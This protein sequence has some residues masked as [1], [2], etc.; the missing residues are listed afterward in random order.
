MNLLLRDGMMYIS[1]D[2]SNQILPYSVYSEDH[3]VGLYIKQGQIINGK[4][5]GLGR[6]I[7]IEKPKYT[8]STS[9]TGD[10]DD[11]QTR[12]IIN[13]YDYVVISEGQ[14]YQDDL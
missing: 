1:R 10:D 11:T 8:N 2:S 9:T 4:L 12:R 13:D 14:F 6:K 5:I 7:S 3:W